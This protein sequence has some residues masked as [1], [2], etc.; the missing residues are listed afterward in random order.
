MTAPTGVN[1]ASE[2]A[3]I[4]ARDKSSRHR[5]SRETPTRASDLDRSPRQWRGTGTDEADEQEGKD[6]H[7]NDQPG[8]ALLGRGGCPRRGWPCSHRGSQFIS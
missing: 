1:L 8:M 6:D 4:C 7:E 3:R 5:D 2:A